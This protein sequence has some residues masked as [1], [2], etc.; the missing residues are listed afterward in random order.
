MQI[1]RGAKAGITCIA[2]SLRTSATKSAL[3]QVPV[4]FEDGICSLAKGERA[5]ISCP[6]SKARSEGSHALLPDPPDGADRV[7]FEVELL[8]MIQVRSHTTKYPRS[9]RASL[10]GVTQHTLASQLL[11]DHART[12]LLDVNVAHGGMPCR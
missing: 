9:R 1:K 6:V 10:S 4:G 8:R 5:F 7:E 2:K 12:E 11:M 3:Q